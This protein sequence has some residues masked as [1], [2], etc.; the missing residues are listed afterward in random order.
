MWLLGVYVA[1]IQGYRDTGVQGHGMQGY[2]DAGASRYRDIG[3]E[4]YRDTRIKRHTAADNSE[5]M[6]VTPSKNY[7]IDTFREALVA[8]KRTVALPVRVCIHCMHTRVHCTCA[9][10]GV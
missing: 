4:R 1:D 9:R 8:A 5:A 3:A 10:A 2:K 6:L 7:S